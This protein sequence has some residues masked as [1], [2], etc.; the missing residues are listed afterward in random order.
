[1]S[2]QFLSGGMIYNEKHNRNIEMQVKIKVEMSCLYTK[3]ILNIE[4]YFAL[5]TAWILLC[6]C[7]IFSRLLKNSPKPTRGLSSRE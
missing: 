6:L 2:L 7:S 3:H 4:M 1:M 5:I